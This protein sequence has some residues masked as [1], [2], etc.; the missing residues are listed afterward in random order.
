MKSFKNHLIS[1]KSPGES[2]DFNRK[3]IYKGSAIFPV[4]SNDK[5]NSRILFMG[6]WIIKKN[7]KEIGLLY[8]LRNQEGEVMLRKSSQ[9]TSPSST[10]IDLKYLLEETEKKYQNFIGSIELE[11]FSNVDLVFPYP[12]FVIN[13]YNNMSSTLVHTTGRIYNDF[14]DMKNNE[15]FKVKESGFD[16]IS[17]KN[18]EPFFSFV[19]GPLINETPK[20]NIELIKEENVIIKKELSL[21]SIKPFET[22]FIHLKK[23]LDI[24]KYLKNDIGTIKIDHNLK[25]FFPRFIAGNLETETNSHSIT[26]TFY[27]NSQN[28]SKDAYWTNNHQNELYDSTVFIPLLVNDDWY[29]ELKLYPIYSPSKHSIS[30]QFYDSEGKIIGSKANFMSMNKNK[31][32]QISMGKIL[33]QL[34]IPKD[35]V[36]GANLIKTWEDKSQIPSRLKYGLNIGKKNKKYDIPT[37]ICFASHLSNINTLQKKGTFKWFPLINSGESLGI[38][39]N[40][41]FIKN[42]DKIANIKVCFYNNEQ[43]ESI[44]RDYIIAPNGQLR[45]TFDKELIKFSKNLPIWVTV[46]SD[47]PFIK[48]WYFEFNDSGIMGGDHSF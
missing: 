2:I 34:N 37:N 14:E 38:I 17:R 29:T 42:Y 30:I 36:M 48:A 33:T 15:A 39:E 21:E 22:K 35:N 25:G 7:I 43:K 45:I 3:P 20:I 16:I 31:F 12:A 47:N 24:E 40:S 32:V 44:E 9:I 19:N 41:S 27:D 6:Y 23:F 13:Y 26:H 11:I 28:N 18:V 8:T 4:I 46:N 5:I 10:E 1:I